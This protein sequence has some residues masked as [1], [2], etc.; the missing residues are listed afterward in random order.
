MDLGNFPAT[1]QVC[2]SSESALPGLLETDIFHSYLG[3]AALAVTGEPGLK[4]LDSPLCISIDAK[5]N[6]E[7]LR[8]D[9][10]VPRRRY[11]LHGYCFEIREDDPRCKEMMAKDEGPPKQ[12]AEAFAGAAVN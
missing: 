9:P 12:L 5:K 2:S 11:W 4:K 8:N 10:S 7:R 6:L 1:L 3:L